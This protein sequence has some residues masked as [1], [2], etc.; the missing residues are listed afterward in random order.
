MIGLGHR[1]LLQRIAGRAQ[2]GQHKA[3]HPIGPV[4]GDQVGDRRTLG[5]T[6]EVESLQT[7]SVGQLD[8]QSRE[9]LRAGRHIAVRRLA[10]ARQIQGTDTADVGQSVRGDLPVPQ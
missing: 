8:E 9:Y 7:Q 3:I 2:A 1:E 6:V 10:V 4:Y 5:V